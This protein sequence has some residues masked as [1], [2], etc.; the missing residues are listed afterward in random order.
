MEI[1]LVLALS[2]FPTPS[3]RRTLAFALLLFSQPA[4]AV[5]TFVAVTFADVAFAEDGDNG[6]E[7]KILYPVA[8][9][10]YT[11][12]V[13]DENN[14]P[15]RGVDVLAAGIRCQEDPGSWYGWPT[16]N[17]GADNVMLTDANGEV[18]VQYPVR[19]GVPPNWFTTTTIDFRFSHPHF[20]GGSVEVD[21][22]AESHTHQLVAGC[23]AHF[24]A[25]DDVGNQVTQFYVAIA[26]AGGLARWTLNEGELSTGGIPEGGWQ[27][28]L[29]SPQSDGRHLFS[30]IL[31]A[32]YAQGK[33][34]TIRGISLTPGLRLTGRLADN[35][36][37]PVTH[38]QITA[39]C[40]PKPRGQVYE[41]KDP[42][43]GW[44]QAI[45]IEQDGTFN[46]PSLPR[47]GTVQLIAVCRSWVVESDAVA[48]RPGDNR[49]TGI[50]INLDEL[51]IVDNE[52]PGIIV[53]MKPTG[54]LEVTVRKDDG[55]PL[56]GATV[57]SWPNQ[58][59]D[60]G[61]STILGSEYSSIDAIRHVLDHAD[62]PYFKRA[63]ATGSRQHRYSVTTDAQGHAVLYDLP[64]KMEHGLYVGNEEY[65]QESNP[66]PDNP[67]G[68]QRFTLVD[69]N[70]MQLGVQVVKVE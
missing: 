8:T 48:D 3:V 19:F 6:D 5:V 70:P 65:R 46:F 67:R 7:A 34:V 29:V 69:A 50:H 44:S 56:E 17:V 9:K 15:L 64:L 57:A 45:D 42:S 62:E 49:I 25:K 41:D 40:L 51:Q 26:G 61:G 33:D 47:S 55:S 24:S 66:T 59:Y 36:P 31:P 37:R 20:V 10:P 38:G 63:W 68:E 12:K 2:T 52:L 27:T 60:K 11:L 43:L 28:M 14:Q 1:F 53:P 35:V 23:P 54:T 22:A 21:T 58:V 39:W 32:R 13:V 4:L 16:P 30:G 18:T